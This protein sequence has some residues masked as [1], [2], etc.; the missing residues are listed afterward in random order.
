MP[1]TQDKL[2]RVWQRIREE[3]GTS[4]HRGVRIT[5]PAVR[6][7]MRGPGKTVPARLVWA[8]L[9]QLVHTGVAVAGIGL[10][11][12]SAAQ[13]RACILRAKEAGPPGKATMQERVRT[14]TAGRGRPQR[15]GTLLITAPMAEQAVDNLRQGACRQAVYAALL[16][17]AHNGVITL[18]VRPA[19]KGG[20]LIPLRQWV[21]CHLDWAWHNQWISK[22]AR[23]QIATALHA[24]AQLRTIDDDQPTII[25]LGTGW[26]GAWEGMTAAGV[27]VVTVDIM[28]QKIGKGRMT[29]PDLIMDFMQGG[30]RLVRRVAH[31]A[32]V[33]KRALIGVFASPSCKDTSVANG[34]GKGKGGRGYYAGK[35][36]L[37]SEGL[38]ELLA[39]LSDY[40]TAWHGKY[41]LENPAYSSLRFNRHVRKTLGDNAIVTTGC[42]FGLKHEKPYRLWTNLTHDDAL[43]RTNAA[44]WCNACR[45]GIGHEHK[46]C[47]RRGDKTPRPTAPGLYGE[48]ARNR[49]PL[50]LGRTIAE[51]FLAAW[52]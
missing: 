11:I 37:T 34:L 44:E 7:A 3:V 21:M 50:L 25:E 31:L 24:G 40:T 43:W 30:G 14:W 33:R 32:K 19:G 9:A 13:R 52:K 27:R 45:Q 51:A 49:M 4:R 35:G 23:K 26:E 22:S 18:E 48:A 38:K 6:A 36:N 28:Q 8:H 2:D 39:G 12:S 15:D 10:P 42:A 29:H 47:P 16:L 5:A 46:M 41:V 1:T 17:A 20:A